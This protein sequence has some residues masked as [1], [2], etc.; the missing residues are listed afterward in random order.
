MGARTIDKE[1]EKLLEDGRDR[2]TLPV[3]AHRTEKALQMRR[4]IY[5]P[6]VSDEQTQSG[7]T[8]DGI[9]GDRNVVDGGL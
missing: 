7:T 4:E 6:K 5:P 9:F 1:A 8:R 2:Q 3:L